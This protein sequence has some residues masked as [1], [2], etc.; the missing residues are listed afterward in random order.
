M[1]RL[2]L[3]KCPTSVLP[4]S[5]GLESVWLKDT[6]APLKI[7]KGTI[8]DDIDLPNELTFHLKRGSGDL[9]LNL[10]KN[11]DINPN[12]DEYFVRKLKD[13]QSV[14]VKIENVEKEDVA[15]YQ[16]KENEA[17]VTVRCAKRSNEECDRSLYGNIRIGRR[18]Y[19]LRPAEIDVTSRELSDVPGFLGKPYTLQDEEYIRGYSSAENKE[20][21]HAS[22]KEMEE[23]L[24]VLL[25]R[26]DAHKKHGN[27]GP[28]VDTSSARNV[29]ASSN[30]WAIDKSRQ[31]KKAYEVEVAVLVD[32][33]I[34]SLYSSTV[35]TSNPIARVGFVKRK[36]KE[37]FSHIMNGV[38]LRY[39]T[40]DDPRISIRVILCDFIFLQDNSPFTTSKDMVV[41]GTQYV[42]AKTY[43]LDLAVWDY[44]VGANRLPLFDHGM[45]FTS[46]NL[47][48]KSTQDPIQGLTYTGEVCNTASKMSIVQ[49]KDYVSTVCSAAHELAHREISDYHISDIPSTPVLLF[50]EKRFISE[51]CAN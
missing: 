36:I 39:K 46:Q 18:S 11:Q 35:G 17:F 24:K 37:S 30:R 3:N 22:E 32:E 33:S 51:E 34:W 19:D 12:A 43:L 40:I 45:L 29:P 26:F 16:D 13:G 42:E 41:D 10:K 1:F 38:N 21:I 27:I 7:D 5:K 44:K 48:L 23:G 2:F 4:E 9:T 31:L 8:N 14:L 49:A 6:T 50:E 15:Y 47:Y 28:A 25:R 20:T